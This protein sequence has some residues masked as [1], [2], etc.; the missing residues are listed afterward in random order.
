LVGAIEQAVKSP[1]IGEKLA[2]LGILQSHATPEQATTEIR[3]ELK[4]V[5][6]MA[7]KTGFVK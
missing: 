3:E 6:E 4:R 5:S 7:R 2:P 1:T